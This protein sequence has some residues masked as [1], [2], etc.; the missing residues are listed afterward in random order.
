MAQQQQLQIDQM[1]ASVPPD[2]KSFF[3]IDEIKLR[4][5]ESDLE[6]KNVQVKQNQEYI[7]LLSQSLKQVDTILLLMNFFIG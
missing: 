1:R 5:L 7:E 4:A 6:H 3:S 2:Q